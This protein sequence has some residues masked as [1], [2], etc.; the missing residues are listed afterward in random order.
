MRHVP[1]VNESCSTYEWVPYMYLEWVPYMYLQADHVAA[2][3]FEHM[4]T[5]FDAI[6]HSSGSLD[7][8][9]AQVCLCMCIHVDGRVGGWVVVWV[10]G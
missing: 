5:E 8:F 7:L 3:L 4:K 2:L 6:Q 9:K 10:G 1:R